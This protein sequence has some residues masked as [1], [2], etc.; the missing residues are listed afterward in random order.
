MSFEEKSAWILG[1]LAAGTYAAYL[2]IILG[3]AGA[4]PLVEVP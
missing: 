3:R 4:T 1:V 2:T